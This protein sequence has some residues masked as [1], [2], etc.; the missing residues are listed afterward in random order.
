M[1]DK[2]SLK[3]LFTNKTVKQYHKYLFI[4]GV[5]DINVKEPV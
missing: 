2:V 1:V 5:F 3:F 4:F